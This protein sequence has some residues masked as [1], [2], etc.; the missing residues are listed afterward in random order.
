MSKKRNKDSKVTY[1][2]VTREDKSTGDLYLPIPLPLLKQLGWTEGDDIDFKVDNQGRY[3]L[4]RVK[5]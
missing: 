2:V 4:S 1:E 3:I 5:K